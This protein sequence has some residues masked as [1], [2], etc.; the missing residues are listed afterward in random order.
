MKYK[1]MT[2]IRSITYLT[3][4]VPTLLCAQ[5]DDVNDIRFGLKFSPNLAWINPDMPLVE[6][7]GSQFGYTFGLIAELPVG[8]G[9]YGF[10]TGLQL[11]NIGGAITY[12]FEYSV[13][14]PTDTLTSVSR[15]VDL[16]NEYQLQYLSIP[17]Q[18]KLKTN[19]IGYITYFGLVGLDLGFNIRAKADV[20]EVTVAT[21][22]EVL[23]E[24]NEELDVLD[25]IKFFRTALVVGAGIEYNFSGPTSL[26]VGITFNSG[27]SNVADRIDLIEGQKTKLLANYLELNLGV[28]F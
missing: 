19:E 25:E 7:R 21:F 13:V 10:N 22:D 14:D 2:R 11:T 20:D 3:L 5:V 28:F 23:I 9:N 15:S 16:A 17:L 27:F 4:L 24:T 1:G 26:L 18:M 8:T 6:Q 12:P